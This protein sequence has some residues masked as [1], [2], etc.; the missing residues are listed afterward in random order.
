MRSHDFNYLV[1]VV[2]L[3][4]APILPQMHCNTV[5]TGAFGNVGSFGRPRVCRPTRLP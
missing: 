4:M 1:E 3:N 2:I 5:G